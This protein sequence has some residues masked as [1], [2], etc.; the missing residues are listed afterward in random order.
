MIWV[1]VLGAFW[2]G[3]VLGFTLMAVLAASSKRWEW[4]DDEVEL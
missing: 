4:E 1:A 2:L 3:G